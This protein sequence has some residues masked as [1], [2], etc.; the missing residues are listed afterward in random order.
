MWFIEMSSDAPLRD[1]VPA[2]SPAATIK[3][4]MPRPDV[5]GISPT[6]QTRSA[7][8]CYRGCWSVV[9]S[10]D[11]YFGLTSW[12]ERKANPCH[13]FCSR[14][15]SNN[16]TKRS[17]SCA[18]GCNDP[19][20]A[21]FVGSRIV[22]SFVVLVGASHVTVEASETSSDENGSVLLLCA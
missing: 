3:A 19:C 8:L 10:S 16:T 22:V 14:A 2:A 20:A 17:Q 1:A 9:V 5:A 7:H 12:R 15:S 18:K 21:I 4:G 13:Y 6:R 11:G